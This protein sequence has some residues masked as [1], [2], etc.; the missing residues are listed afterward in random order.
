MTAATRA[1]PCG[2]FDGLPVSMMLSGRHFE[3]STIYK[4]AYAFEQSDD[5]K[6]V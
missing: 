2:L 5:W 4:A 6:T 3:E 1:V